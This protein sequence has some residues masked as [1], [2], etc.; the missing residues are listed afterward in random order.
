MLLDVRL[1][2]SIVIL[3]FKS[4]SFVENPPDTIIAITNKGMKL[5]MR[6]ASSQVIA[7]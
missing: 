4:L 6:I 1:K 5:A 7:A 3:N 2:L